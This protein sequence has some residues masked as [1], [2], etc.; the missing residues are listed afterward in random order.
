MMMEWFEKAVTAITL[1]C[2]IVVCVIL[3]LFEEDDELF[4][5]DDD[6]QSQSVMTGKFPRQNDDVRHTT[7]SRHYSEDSYATGIR[8]NF[9]I[10][11]RLL[12][13][14]RFV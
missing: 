10:F 6:S 3:V 11:L 4:Y 5:D 14:I 7:K 13:L 1:Y 12:K 8:E 2:N 9:T